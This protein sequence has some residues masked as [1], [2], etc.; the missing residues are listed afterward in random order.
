MHEE[1]LQNI[2]AKFYFKDEI[3]GFE[4]LKQA[5]G[6]ISISKVGVLRSPDGRTKKSKS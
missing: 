4:M 2:W 5:F 6:G 1:I 3:P